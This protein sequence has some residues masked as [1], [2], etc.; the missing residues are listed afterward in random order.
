MEYLAGGDLMTL[1]QKR[2]ILSD[3]VKNNKRKQN[4]I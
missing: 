4:F 3:N 2:D 1:L